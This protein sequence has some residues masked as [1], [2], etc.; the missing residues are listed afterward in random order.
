[1]NGKR[2][3]TAGGVRAILTVVLFCLPAAAARQAV[4]GPAPEVVK[5]LLSALAALKAH[6]EGN[7]SLD[8]RRVEAHKLTIDKHREL[9]G[10]DDTIIKAAFDVVA[11][12]DKVNGPLWV[13]GKSFN[14]GR[15][16]K[17]TPPPND[18]HWTVYNVMQNIMDFVYTPGNIA[19]YADILD[20]LKFGCS[21]HF[22]GAVAPPGDPDAVY[23][24]RINAGYPKP[25]KHKIMH[26]ERPKVRV[27]AHCWDLSRKP[28]VLR[29]DRV[30]LLYPIDSTD[31]K[32][33]SPL[34]GGIYIEVPLRADAAGVVEIAIRNAV[35]SPYFSAK[36]FHRTSLD[37]WRNVERLHKAPWA[38]LQSEK[39]M[40]QAPTSWIYKLDDPVTLMADWDK[41]MDAMNDL[42][43]LP[44]VWGKEAMY[45]QVD[46]Q[47]RG[48]AFFPGYP[49]SNSRYDPNKDY[50]GNVDHYFLRGPRYAPGHVF[51]EAGHGF[52]F[53]KF[54]G[55]HESTVNLPHVAVWHRMFGKSLDEAFA[56]S[57]SMQ[58]NPHRTLDNTAVTW[59]TCL[60]FIDGKPMVAGEKAYQLK[61]WKVLGDYWRSWV[62]DFE[63]GRPWSKHGTEYDVLNLRLSKTAG[64]DLT[65]LLH[66][67]GIH[68]GDAAALKAAVAAEELPAS[69]K[70]Y[71]T[72]VRYKSMVPENKQAFREFARKWWGKQPNPKG[73]MTERGH[74]KLWEEFNEETSGQIKKVVQDILDR[75]F[76][77]GRPRNTP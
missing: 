63:A 72:L 38:D 56:S 23:R 47:F 22:P 73:Y 57:R 28:R 34:G 44:R 30:T 4:A 11:T 66:F 2:P 67:W 19:R 53:V 52:L 54:G 61:G 60:N 40:M 48:S 41:A 65:P 43:G 74:A 1:M 18:I 12:Y 31:V 50:G 70:V 3:E 15:S 25:F 76:P 10:S 14:R 37:E 39:F 49:T 77:K 5:E 62:D 17:P 7:P 29:L 46:L 27:G 58:K 21:A 68:P 24:V 35:R 33:A 55:E 9:F 71:D 75:Y 32:V 64:V 42:M 69:A 20:G 36:P 59:M 45:Q 6:V 13:S 8:A 16:R 51:H 26:E